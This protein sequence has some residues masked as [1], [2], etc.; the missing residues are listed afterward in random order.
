M[1]K[2]SKHDANHVSVRDL[3]LDLDLFSVP[4]IKDT[5]TFDLRQAQRLKDIDD[6]LEEEMRRKRR[7][8]EKEIR[9]MREEFLSLY[10]DDG[11]NSAESSSSSFVARRRGSADVLD[12]KKMRTLIVVDSPETGNRKFRIRFD[13]SGFDRKTVR[14]S[15]D[16]ERIVVRAAKVEV[17]DLDPKVGKI[18]QFCR[19]VV[20]PKD[21]DPSKF[22]SYLTS[23][24]VLI[25]E[26]P[27]PPT[28]ANHDPRRAVPSPSLGKGQGNVPSS[29]AR[30]NSPGQD[31]GTPSSSTKEK[32]GVPIFREE[33]ESGGRRMHL[34]VE[35]GTGFSP[36]E[37]LV[38]AVKDNKILVRAKH[39]DR[40]PERLSKNKYCKE[41]EL[42]E[43]IDAYSLT[44]SLEGDGRLVVG[45]GVKVRGRKKTRRG[46]GEEE[47]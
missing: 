23:D 10:P 36:A 9:K 14:V 13:V 34:V 30:S 18:R 33:E 16:S 29:P 44:A 17:N 42:G 3:D 28:P 41:F 1:E 37:V 39:E 2:T 27:L 6:H 8:W 21:A 40:T 35:L 7:G 25:V 19:K 12:R 22:K 31:G 47:E 43:K 11:N 45:A 20:L 46:A 15:T 38:Q 32:I 24:S 4:V 26:A 5:R